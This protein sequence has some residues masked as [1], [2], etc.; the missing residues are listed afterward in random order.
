MMTVATY[1]AIASPGFNEIEEEPTISEYY[2]VGDE[3]NPSIVDGHSVLSGIMD[4]V[5]L[6]GINKDQVTTEVE[7]LQDT[8][9]SVDGSRQDSTLSKEKQ[10]LPLNQLKIIEPPYSPELIKLFS[11]KDETN[12]RCIAAK[13]QDAVGRAWTLEVE[14]SIKSTP[15]NF[16]EE[17]I[18]DAEKLKQAT[19]QIQ[20]A[21]SFFTNCNQVFGLEGVLLKAAMDLESIGWCA[22]EVIRSADMKV[23]SL[24]YA[25]ADKFR[26]VE[27]WKGF[28]ELR[29]GGKK[30][31][32]QPFG[33]K[34]L[35][36][37][38]IDPMTNKGYPYSPDLD[39]ELTAEN[40]EFNMIDWAEGRPTD[41]FLSSANE[42]I[43]IVKHHP[44]TLYYGISDVVPILPK[45]LI[46]LNINQ[47]S[48]QFF[49]HN[50]I[51]RY[52]IIIKGA[53]LDNAVKDAI[54]KYFQT[55][56]K[57]RAHKTLILPLPTGRGNVE[58]VFQKLDADNQD[59]WFREQYKD[60]A[61]SIRISHGVT[62]AIIG[63]SET[64]SLG[65]GK[66]LSQAEIYKDRI[67]IPSQQ[68]WSAI[69]NNILS[70]GRGLHLICVV[71]EEIDTRDNET[72]MRVFS[73][74][75][76]RGIVTINQVR[77]AGGLG[78]PI[79]G[80]DRAFIKVGNAILFVDEMDGM[81]STLADPMELAKVN[82]EA[83][84]KAGGDF[85]NKPP[86]NAPENTAIQTI[87]RGPQA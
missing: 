31:F 67:V 32:Y 80:G 41:N 66:G 53:K 54:L 25:P 11:Q 87:Q 70:V 43:W 42:I 8:L 78:S 28:L 5:T 23:H 55:E 85:K 83:K 24:D 16:D 26:V 38:R 14:K 52:V 37:K 29:E 1:D 82:A 36:K 75:F 57:G 62:A 45:I 35:S 71:F 56:V 72:K 13:A 19:I 51:P 22:I 69:L 64:A 48:L 40:A 58:V 6:K 44:A 15:G 21:T 61:D 20:E 27:G 7:A 47:Y 73:G 77:A 12:T 76:D 74:Y 30:V 18:V 81:K 2:L 50:T 79:K 65:S 34:V 49:E 39:G 9:K 68:R 60:N 46:N 63:Q 59:G 10:G 17:D 4:Q 3:D 84:Q 86:A 33:Q